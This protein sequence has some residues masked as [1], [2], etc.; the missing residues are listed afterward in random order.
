MRLGAVVAVALAVSAVPIGTASGAAA[1]PLPAVTP[2]IVAASSS[3]TPAWTKLTPPTSPSVRDS[4][5][6]A[7]DPATGQLVLY[8]GAGGF[9]P[10]TLAVDHDTWT[11]DGASWSK[12]ITTVTPGEQDRLSGGSMAYDPASKQLVLLGLGDGDAMGTWTWNGSQWTTQHPAQ[13]PVLTGSCMATDSATGELVLYGLHAT[14]TR[15]APE[16]SW[17]TWTW[18]GGNWVQLATPAI[19]PQGNNAQICSM[20]YD[21]ANQDLLLVTAT[22]Y[23]GEAPGADD[24]PIETWTFDGT[25][26]TKREAALN[27]TGG[28]DF[29][30][31]TYDP[32][33]GQV[34]T[35]GGFDVTHGNSVLTN[36]WSWNGSTWQQ[37]T[38]TPAPPSRVLAA[39]A[40]DAATDQLVLFGGVGSTPG[41]ATRGCCRLADRRR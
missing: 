31:M 20:T 39:S 34:M 17:Q 5:L 26:W 11:F 37:V 12:H 23:E 30:S 10:G 14:G 2:A 28:I 41:S 24:G 27:T 21:A 19:S 4:S 9:F 8:G 6:S 13:S 22:W 7:F 29:G 33:Y 36:P 1:G 35:Y 3:T 15:F 32:A 40:Y 18:R 38:L 16:L 25:T